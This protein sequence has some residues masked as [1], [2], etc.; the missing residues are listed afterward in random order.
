MSYFLDGILKLCFNYSASKVLGLVTA[1]KI[2]HNNIYFQ[3]CQQTHF[4]YEQVGKHRRIE[5]FVYL[6]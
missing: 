6:N 5:I 2:I 1:V 3:I 4:F